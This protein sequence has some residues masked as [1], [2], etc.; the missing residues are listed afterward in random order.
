MILGEDFSFRDDLKKDT[1]PIE[2]LLDP[3]KGIIYRYINVS[4]QENDNDTA[5]LKFDYDLYEMG[6]FTETKLIKDKRFIEILGLILNTLI[7]EAG[8]HTGE[9]LNEHRKI[10]SEK[11][12]QE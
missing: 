6:D 12:D 2:L 8:E 5:T 11:S 3:Y 10:D 7:L 4:V 9:E 1:V